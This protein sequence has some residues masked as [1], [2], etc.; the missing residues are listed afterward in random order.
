MGEGFVPLADAAP[1]S[2]L[3][4][5]KYARAIDKLDGAGYQV[6]ITDLGFAIFDELVPNNVLHQMEFKDVIRYRHDAQNARE[7]F[8][9]YLSALQQ[10]MGQIKSDSGYA[11]TID[12]LIVNEVI[13]AAKQFK[14]K[15]QTIGESFVGT[16]AKGA[17]GAGGAASGVQ[18]LGDLSL[19]HI[20]V[21]AGLTSAYVGQAAIEAALAHRAV[22]RD[23]SLSYVLSLD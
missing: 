17:M 14:N 11:E 7:E 21:L 13:P 10:K 8:L 15:M 22:R 20:L 19:S 9:E 12:H 18:I 3:I 5:S 1:Y 23:C 16:L 4:G 2:N 6:P